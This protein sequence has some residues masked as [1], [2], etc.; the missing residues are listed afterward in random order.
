V[1]VLQPASQP[2]GDL[3]DLKSSIGDPADPASIE[4]SIMACG[5]HPYHG[6][7]V[8][9]G[10]ARL[11]QAYLSSV[12]TSK[13]S[14]IRAVSD[15][16]IHRIFEPPFGGDFG[17]V[18]IVDFY[19]NRVQPCS[20]SSFSE[21]QVYYPNEAAYLPSVLSLVGHVTIPIQQSWRGPWGWWHGPHASQSW[22]YMGA[23]PGV[24]I[25][26]YGLLHAFR[27]LQ[28]DWSLPQREYIQV[29]PGD[30]TALSEVSAVSP[31]AISAA[32]LNWAAQGPIAPMAQ[33]TDTGTLI[34]WQ[35]AS[36]LAAVG[37]GIGAG[38]LSVLIFEVLRPRR[39][40]DT[41]LNHVNYDTYDRT[42]TVKPQRSHLKWIVALLVITT[43]VRIYRWL[44]RNGGI[45]DE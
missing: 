21:P 30:L 23:L 6:V 42:A 20:S 33:I 27:G 11:A 34:I 25:H 40:E 36:V 8:L 35:Q 16:M 24:P 17:N 1:T 12:G 2:A 3:I 9:G 45:A 19:F 38:L 32:G 13:S 18:Q 28:G 43:F 22:P 37:L 4:Y 41:F 5:S 29:Q 39:D 10:E 26:Y 44:F 31:P 7:L 14:T 15:L